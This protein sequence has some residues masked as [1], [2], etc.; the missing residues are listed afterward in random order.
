VPS[1]TSAQIIKILNH[2]AAA[3]LQ[4]RTVPTLSEIIRG[5]ADA[6]P[7]RELAV[8]DL[9]GRSPVQLEDAAV[10]A[11]LENKVVLV[12]GAGGSI[13]SEL[14]RQIAHFN[15]LRIIG[16]D[17]SETALFYLDR[18]LRH[19]FPHL[20]FEPA[21]GS[22]QNVTRL[23]EIFG[24]NQIS[25]VYHAAAYKHV[26]MMENHLFQA[27][28]NNVVGTFNLARV[29]EHFGVE[30][31]VMISSDKAVRPTSIMGLTKRVSEILTRSLQGS[32]TKYVS[33]R[34]GN[35]LG[36]NGSVVP[37]FKQQIAA[38]GPVTVTH[39]EMRRFFMTIPE[40]VQLVLQASTMG[41]G[42]EIFVLDMGEPV[43]IVDLVQN[44]ILLSGRRP[45]DIQIEFTGPR[46]GEKLYE[47]TTTFEEET[48]PTFHEKISVFAGD[49]VLIEDA[50]AWMS[51]VR[52]MC[53]SR[54]L[55]LILFFKQLVPDYSPSA[56]VLESLV[57]FP[58]GAASEDESLEI[59]RSQLRT[60]LP[61]TA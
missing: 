46:S 41:K 7:V 26:P 23:T 17:I 11:K 27:V 37:I 3:H 61:M 56:Q 54:D 25:T 31:F 35:V 57:D 24:S 44:M 40:A 15:P 45:T 34:F 52:R 59:L 29:A 60:T 5:N 33:V 53:G 55:R 32:T 12:T 48:L 58:A 4:F 42:G 38:G 39:R 13:G 18:E 1:A 22:V 20:T 51:D 8:E 43:K 36:S 30:D 14:C 21:I 9:L 50:D 16:L 28:E 10:R 19:D 6:A 49:G 47:E 2:C